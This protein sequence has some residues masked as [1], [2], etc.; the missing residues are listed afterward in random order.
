M[1][2][3]PGVQT[4]GPAVGRMA[5]I[6]L[7]GVAESGRK[8]RKEPYPALWVRVCEHA[9]VVLSK[10]SH[11]DWSGRAGAL[12]A[13][14]E[15][16][17]AAREETLRNPTAELAPVPR[18]PLWS[19]WRHSP[20][21]NDPLRIV[22]SPDEGAFVYEHDLVHALLLVAA[23]GRT[24]QRRRQR[25]WGSCVEARPSAT[26]AEAHTGT[27]LPSLTLTATT[28]PRSHPPMLSL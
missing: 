5:L 8:V 18:R 7:S 14:R 17:A 19:V 26:R 2:L 23:R 3:G 28:V 10:V 9:S 20:R 6:N 1:K 4:C 16:A 24:R 13:L 11:D 25:G 12:V 27:V 15:G 21:A 22:R